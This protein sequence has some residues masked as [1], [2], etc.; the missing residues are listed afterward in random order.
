MGLT[1]QQRA[2]GSMG[3]FDP[4]IYKKLPGL[5]TTP[6]AGTVGGGAGAGRGSDDGE[7]RGG[8]SGNLGV[9]SGQGVSSDVQQ[10]ALSLI[11][12]GNKYPGFLP[13]GIF[14]KA[15]GLLGG[16]TADSQTAKMAEAQK[17][18]EAIDKQNAA[19]LESRSSRTFDPYGGTKGVM[20][21]SDKE[22]NIRS[23]DPYA[24]DSAR[25]A[26]R[27]AA[28]A[29]S[30][31]DAREA[32]D[33]ENAAALGPAPAPAVDVAPAVD[34]AG[35][36]FGPAAAPLPS[37]TFDDG[38]SI[39]NVPNSFPGNYVDPS[40]AVPGISGLLG[41]DTAIDNLGDRPQPN[42]TASLPSLG[43]TGT[44]LGL[45]GDFLGGSAVSLNPA[46]VETIEATPNPAYAEQQA[47]AQAQAQFQA[48]E[49]AAQ[50]Q[51][52]QAYAEQQAQAQAQAQFQAQER[53]AQAQAEAQSQAQAQAQ[54]QAEAQAQA[55]REASSSYYGGG[56][57]DSGGGGGTGSGD[58]NSGGEAGGG[59][60][61]QYR[62]GL[63]TQRDVKG[64]NPPGPDD[65]L[66]G[67]DI[68]EYVIRKSAVKKYGSNIFEKINAGQIPARRLKSLLE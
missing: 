44:T 28:L 30:I 26:D 20:S 59:Y 37:P 12:F 52:Q 65:G 53:A 27:A 9:G 43:Y 45:L 31:A 18:I 14:A 51:A 36:F 6:A 10:T 56:G 19:A 13:G 47:Q 4:S 49:R 40:T 2:A 48:Q 55:N 1:P 42:P 3:G 29:A 22:G 64:P 21:V 23:F 39:S 61:A 46:P 38:P 32:R 41:A 11:A 54:A 5:L 7:G 24:G 67:L 17:A 50:A 66:S 33:I 63:I 60:G 15:L 35:E 68:G 8:G 57:G 58:G 62:G 34:Y 25:D 16:L